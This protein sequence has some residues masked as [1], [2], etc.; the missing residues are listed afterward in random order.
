MWLMML[1]PQFAS[2]HLFFSKQHLDPTTSR[3]LPK[4]IH[5]LPYTIFQCFQVTIAPALVRASVLIL[6][7]PQLQMDNSDISNLRMTILQRVIQAR[8]NF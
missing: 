7:H 1:L 4:Q 2:A 8:I 6:I 5:L 3:K